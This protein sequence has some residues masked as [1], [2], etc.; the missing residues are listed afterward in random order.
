MS[1][2]AEVEQAFLGRL[3]RGLMLSAADVELVARWERSGAPVE[4]VL[5]GLAAAFERPGL[6][7]GRVR[8]LGFAR[9][10]VESAIEAWRQRGV[11]AFVGSREGVTPDEELGKLL[12][13]RESAAPAEF[14]FVFQQLRV[15]LGAREDFVA[16][17]AWAADAAWR[18]MAPGDRQ[19][20]ESELE[21]SLGRE[22][23]LADPLHFAETWEA[24]RR[25]AVRARVG[26]PEPGDLA[27]R[28]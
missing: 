24:Q 3:G 22:R 23:R 2:L 17:W 21:R 25:R 26:L 12:A 27:P 6:A 11:G 28:S 18:V 15:R 1:Y 20:I 13:D 5:D 10:S 7:V 9:R 8:A 16:L 19:A 4:V 14:R